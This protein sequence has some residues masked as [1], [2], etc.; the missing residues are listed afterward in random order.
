[1]KK[2]SI[3][4]TGL[5]VSLLMAVTL[6]GQPSEEGNPADTGKTVKT[7]KTGETGNTGDAPRILPD[8]VITATR[9]ARDPGDLPY[10][11][12]SVDEDSIRYRRPARSLP[13]ALGEVPSVSVQQ[14]ARGLES[15][16][17]RGF[18]GFRTLL[19]VDGIRVNNATFREGPNQYWGL[20]DPLAIERM[21][22]VKGPSSVLY[23]SDAIGGTVNAFTAESFPEGVH[24]GLYYRF[25]GADLS[26]VVR[27][28]IRGFHLDKLGYSGGFTWQSL[29]D[30]RGGRET[31]LQRY[32]GYDSVAG[33]FKLS[34]L[35]TERIEI[36]AAFQAMDQFDVPRTHSTI[37]GVSFEGTEVGSYL[38][39][40]LDHQRRFAYVKLH[41]EPDAEWIEN[42]T[43]SLSYQLIAEEEHRL[44]SDGR[45]RQ[46]GY[47]DH[48]LGAI[49][50]A[51]SPSPIGDWTYGAEYYGDWV[52]SSFRRDFSSDGSPGGERRGPVADD[53]Q[54][55]SVGIF[56]QDEIKP[57]ERLSIIAG[58]RYNLF[59][60]HAPAEGLDPN[61]SDAETYTDLSETF[62]A[63]V[64]SG[65]VIYRATD[66]LSP[67]TGVSQGF[68]A[69]NLSDLTRFDLA[70]SGEQEVPST[71]L[72]PERYI[73]VEAGLRGR[74]EKWGFSASYYYTDIR[75]MIVR[76]PTGEVTG[77]G[78]T[79][80]TRANVG[81]GYLQG[82]ELSLDWNFYEGFTAHGSFWWMD[83]KVDNYDEGALSREPISRILP[84]QWLLGVRW[85]S[86]DR[87]FWVD[88]TLRI[89]LSEDRLS[90]GDKRDVQRIPPGGTPGYCLIGIRGG[91]R[92]WEERLHLFT[93]VENI[94]DEDYRVHGSGVNGPG[95]NFIAGLE[96]R[97]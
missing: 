45:T 86:R 64:G 32:T 77:D 8:V 90:P 24:P 4:I 28:S 21:E 31:G 23:G 54:Y 39:R 57:L 71:D 5:G 19:L 95:T 87:R 7:P 27:P 55:H 25:E 85:D 59:H 94:T 78:D 6:A 79:V 15:P 68:R 34:W 81:D 53:S 72:D 47:G 3:R 20:V 52:L 46:Q 93:G 67:F 56:V 62:Q 12:D 51:V 33:D 91:M 73:S 63:L 18:T 76:F 26:H 41:A 11:T 70:R 36:T 38:R 16:Y 1:V 29:D 84:T 92:L 97:F 10:T 17:I 37:Y 2:R 69:P 43:L 65:R 74:W 13:Q 83:G 75:D 60:A 44:W 96:L 42:I 80:V 48:T 40:E 88:S 50:S 49:L 22:V 66:H 89:V 30:L 61:P 9:S 35:P 82:V 58:G 14:T